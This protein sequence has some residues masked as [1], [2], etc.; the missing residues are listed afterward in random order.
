MTFTNNND[1][2]T[3]SISMEQLNAIWMPF[4]TLSNN[5]FNV[6]KEYATDRLDHIKKNTDHLTDK[7]VKSIENHQ[8]IQAQEVVQFFLQQQSHLMALN[9]ATWRKYEEL[10]TA[11]YTNMQHSSAHQVTTIAKTTT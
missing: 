11:F 1:K 3:Q 5:L 2:N 9:V 8:P 10:I 6:Q 7:V 4:W